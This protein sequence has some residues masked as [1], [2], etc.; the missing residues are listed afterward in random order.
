MIGT[1]VNFTI[2]VATLICSLTMSL[3]GCWVNSR[4]VY[5]IRVLTLS[6]TPP[7]AKPTFL[8]LLSILVGTLYSCFMVIG[9]GSALAS[10]AKLNA[11]YISIIL[12]SLVWTMLVI[13]NTLLASMSR[14]NY[15]H[16]AYGV[17]VKTRLALCDTLKY[18]MGSI[19]IGSFLVPILGIMWGSA[20][21]IDLLQE[22]PN[23]FCCSCANCYAGCASTLV[24]YGNR[25][26]FVHV[27]LHIKS[28]VQ[29]S[30]YAW[31]TF[32]K[33]GLESLIDSDLTSSFCFLSGVAVGAISSL[34]SGI[35]ALV[36]HK[37]YATELSLYAFFIGYLIGRVSMAWQQACI[38]A[39][40]VA[41]AENPQ[42]LEF[43]ST[44]P[45]RIQ[46]LQRLQA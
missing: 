12:L 16:V 41:Y 38:A 11:V 25:W 21:C 24:M 6:A 27:G 35:W 19:C 44:I 34:V 1:S 15:M 5:A 26:G 31:D 3:Y 45:D 2:G 8:I 18:L 10:R 30:K 42:N 33:I 9:I 40:Y 36:L 46:R 17:D 13:R 14:A 32:K 22:G 28:F 7:P 20:R 39:Y 37:S 23:E 29:A 43:D 4:F